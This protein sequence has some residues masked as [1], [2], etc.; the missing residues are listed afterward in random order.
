MNS[1]NTEKGQMLGKMSRQALRPNQQR[2]AQTQM[3]PPAPVATAQPT[4]VQP[5]AQPATVQP[6]AQPIVQPTAQPTATATPPVKD[7]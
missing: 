7:N 5:T 4:T 3:Q 1:Y 6:P 2:G